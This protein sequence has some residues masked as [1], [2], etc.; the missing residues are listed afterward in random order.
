MSNLSRLFAL[1]LMA[2]SLWLIHQPA[3]HA[4]SCD[5]SEY[6]ADCA[7][8]DDADWGACDYNCEHMYF[9]HVQTHSGTCHW[10]GE[11]NP[12]D[13]VANYGDMCSC[14]SSYTRDDCTC[15]GL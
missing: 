5:S 2:G 10:Y 13:C 8:A 11:N 3:V 12:G 4:D 9:Q 7:A 1:V 6:A 15:T 14:F